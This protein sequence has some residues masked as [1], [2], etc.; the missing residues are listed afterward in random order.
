MWSTLGKIFLEIRIMEMRSKCLGRIWGV[1]S[2]FRKFLGIFL[3]TEMGFVAFYVQCLGVP[4]IFPPAIH[5]GVGVYM[6]GGVGVL[7]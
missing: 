2:L 5:G 4:S 3:C 1:P 6:A 7:V